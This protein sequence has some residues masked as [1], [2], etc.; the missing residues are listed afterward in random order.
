RSGAV[1]DGH[2]RGRDHQGPRRRG[3]RAT[4]LGSAPMSVAAEAIAPLRT[5][6]GL[7]WLRRELTPAPGRSAMMLRL[8]IAV[9]ATVVLSM[10]LQPPLTAFSAYM[11]FFVTKENRVVT[12][13]T[14]IGMTLGV[15]LAVAASLLLSI[16]TFDA[17]H[18][19]L[20]LT[21]ATICVAM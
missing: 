14:A 20:P 6:F 21:A 12:T 10:A 13:I 5:P 16:V 1:P 9:V 19:R 11:V 3:R 7:L 17:P 15:T 8:V 4:G 2:L 18:L